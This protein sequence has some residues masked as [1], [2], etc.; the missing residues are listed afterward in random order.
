MEKQFYD[1]VCASRDAILQKVSFKGK[2]GVILGSGLGGLV[3]VMTDKAYIEY[4]DI[5]NFPQSTVKGHA[6]RLVFGKIGDNEIVAMQGRFHYYEGYDMLQVTYPVFVMKMLGV[7]KL[8]VTNS[9]GGINTDFEPGTLM[10]IEDFINLMGTNPLIGANDERFG[11]RFPD[12]T[13]CYN[14]EWLAL[15]KEVAEKE[16]INYGV[17]VYGGTTGPYYETAAE[18]KAFKAM[19][20]DA[21]GMSTVPETIVANYLSMSV[22]GVACITNMATGIQT[23]KHDHANV[24][25]VANRASADFCRLLEKVIALTK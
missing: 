18:I 10:I 3:D 1:F 24:V 20:V 21:I 14:K 12:M 17:G 25:A 16:N 7:E 23:I 2:I 13:E 8:V 6:G 11:T 9:C 5:P 4:K 22:L 19:G 15:T